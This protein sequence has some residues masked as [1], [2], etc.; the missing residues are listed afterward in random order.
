MTNRWARGQELEKLLQKKI[1][2]KSFK[3]FLTNSPEYDK[4]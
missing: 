1:L 4:I 2:K 3:K